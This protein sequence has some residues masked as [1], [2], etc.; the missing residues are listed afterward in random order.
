MSAKNNYPYQDS[1]TK[2]LSSKD[3]SEVTID[4]YNKI[5]TELFNYLSEFNK[6]YQSDHRVENLFNRDIEEYLNML[7]NNRQISN[8]TYNKIL[9][10]IN[11]YF[12]YLFTHNLNSNLPTIELKGL[13][14]TSKEDVNVKWINELDSILKNN[15]VHFYARMTMLLTSKGYKSEEFLQTGFY[16]QLDSINF[17]ENELIFKTSFDE[18]IKPIQEKQRS[19]DIFL[20]QRLSKQPNITIQ[21][22]HKY[23]KPSED[24][25][26]M[27][28]NPSTLFQSYI[29][30]Y[31][32]KNPNLN[33][34]DLSTHLN[35]DLSSINYYKQ[36]AAKLI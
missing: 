35:L 15:N 8:S 34:I 3:L 11:V 2:H 23:L 9:S 33:D 24:V 36:L 4:E 29:V 1:F 32:Q 12:N 14:K 30:F 19:S 31:I 7:L 17:T 18:F 25:L 22:L 13:K 10:H 27:S 26:N 16:K 20:K 5:L 28:L 6:G 21:G